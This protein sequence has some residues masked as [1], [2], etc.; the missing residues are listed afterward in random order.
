MSR[1]SEYKACDLIPDSEGT[2]V[3]EVDGNA[4]LVGR[5][6]FSFQWN[7]VWVGD[8]A[9]PCNL[10]INQIVVSET[11]EGARKG[12]S[13]IK[14]TPSVATPETPLASSSPFSRNVSVIVADP[15]GIA[16]EQYTAAYVLVPCSTPTDNP[17][18]ETAQ[19]IWISKTDPFNPDPA[20][21]PLAA[22]VK[23][24][25]QPNHCA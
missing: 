9:N 7:T 20:V 16:T 17:G 5:E 22:I 1:H 13:L 11:P 18:K 8:Q 24:R 23:S 4:N 25:C 21:T 3:L 12:M 10:W 6:F 2:P 19:K 14:P 15:D